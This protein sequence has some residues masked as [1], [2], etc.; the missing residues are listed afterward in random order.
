VNTAGTIST[1]ASNAGFAGITNLISDSG[2]NLYAADYFG[3]LVWNVTSAGAVSLV[4]GV[5]GVCGFNGD[6]IQATQADLNAPYGLALDST[7]NLYIADSLN[8]R[9]RKVN[10]SGVISTTAGAGT[11]GFS[12]D[13]GPATSAKLC[14]P[15]GL[16]LDTKGNFYLGDAGNYRVRTVNSGGTISTFA[17]MGNRGYNGNGLL[18]TQTNIDSPVGFAISSNIV[19]VVDNVQCRV[20]KIH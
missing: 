14:V 17:G 5:Q 9:V 15:M 1:F 8:N 16:A 4:A 19:Y 2:G 7:G 18:A 3:C 10:T 12:G 13:G 20:R 6:G 11:C